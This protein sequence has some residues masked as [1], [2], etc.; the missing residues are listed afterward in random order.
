MKKETKKDEDRPKD[1]ARAQFN[2]IKEMIEA[3]KA[4]GDNDEEARQTIEEDPLSI[5]VR[6][7]WHIPGQS[8]DPGEYRILLCWGGPAVCIEGE[9]NDYSEPMSAKLL[10]QDWFTAWTKYPLDSDEEQILIEYALCFYYGE[11]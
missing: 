6:S 9:L 1:Q 3:L 8:N 10:Y 4:A 2:S 7:D 11:N 5:E